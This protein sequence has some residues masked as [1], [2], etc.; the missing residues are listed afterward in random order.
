[1]KFFAGA[2]FSLPPPQSLTVAP[3]LS[4]IVSPES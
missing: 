1:M 2:V 4:V 3:A